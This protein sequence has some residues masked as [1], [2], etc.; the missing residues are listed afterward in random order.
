MKKIQFLLM[1]SFLLVTRS[2]LFSQKEIN[3]Y[4]PPKIMEGS[5][6]IIS[7]SPGY[8]GRNVGYE[9]DYINVD[10]N[11]K[12][13]AWKFTNKYDYAFTCQP[14]FNYARISLNYEHDTSYNETKS[15]VYLKAAG[16][17][18]LYKTFLYSGLYSNNSF[19]FHNGFEPVYAIS[20][21]PFI[22]TGKITDAKMVK[23]TDNFEQILLDE[24]IITGKLDPIVRKKLTELFDMRENRD[25]IS[26]YKDDNEIE[27]F[28]KIEN[29]LREHGIIKEYLGAKATLKLFQALTNNAFLYFPFYKGYQMQLSMNFDYA[30]V[31][32]SYTC[33]FNLR[34]DMSLSG[35][36]GVP[37]NNITEAIGVLYFAFPIDSNPYKIALVNGFYNPLIIKEEQKLHNYRNSTIINT[38]WLDDNP[39]N[40]YSYIAGAK[41]LLYRYITSNFGLTGRANVVW[42]KNKDNH[43]DSYELETE[44]GL[45]YYILNSMSLGLNSYYTLNNNHNYNF[46]I[47]TEINYYIF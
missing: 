1:L 27:F 10:F 12:F 39:V 2:I 28:V 23:A 26:I 33:S 9:N 19:E 7:A 40:E 41:I 46:G 30:K 16:D 24:K 4:H 18:Y 43:P 32:N 42:G 31:C 21:S 22:G 15:I 3:N 35:I 8:S 38:N 44:A 11:F 34:K 5:N 6:L 37:I 45:T 29:L 14:Y 20:L 36:I 25:F 47:K 17:I 13:T